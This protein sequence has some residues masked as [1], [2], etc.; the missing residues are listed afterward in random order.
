MGVRMVCAPH[1]RRGQC[2]LQRKGRSVASAP[3]LPGVAYA[4]QVS[5]WQDLRFGED[6]GLVIYLQARPAAALVLAP[7]RA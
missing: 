1:V 7:V 5:S 2:A 6:G 4:P 3:C